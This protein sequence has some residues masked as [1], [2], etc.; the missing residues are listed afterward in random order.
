M[1]NH[2]HS[3]TLILFCIPVHAMQQNY[4]P[5]SGSG[6]IPAAMSTGASNTSVEET[7]NAIRREIVAVIAELSIEHA[8]QE[9]E[10]FAARGGIYQNVV[11]NEFLPRM[12]EQSSTKRLK[13]YNQNNPFDQSKKLYSWC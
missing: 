9:L 11:L 8:L 10:K 3:L 12:Q 13:P 7:K 2:T 5:G 4:F 6:S 1:F